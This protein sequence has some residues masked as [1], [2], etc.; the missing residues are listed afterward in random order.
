MQNAEEFKRDKYLSDKRM[1]FV[2]DRRR[3]EIV[4]NIQNS[5]RTS[6]L[7]LRYDR[8]AIFTRK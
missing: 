3:T 2:R 1:D 5:F 6:F 7:Y 4:F 8:I